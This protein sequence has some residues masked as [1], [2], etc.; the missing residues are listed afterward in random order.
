MRF[1]VFICAAATAYSLAAA[2][3]ITP[4]M[5]DPAR[6]VVLT[7]PE[8]QTVASACGGTSRSAGWTLGFQ[9]IDQLER[10]LAPL[11]R[12]GSSTANTPPVVLALA[13]RYSST[14]FMNTTSRLTLEKPT[15]TA[16]Q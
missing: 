14:A 10:K 11:P 7:G 6:G 5:F 2:A 3:E 4:Q 13:A 8:G 15:G 16:P 12:Y 1:I 9:D